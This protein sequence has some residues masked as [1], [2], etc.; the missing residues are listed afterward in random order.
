L[1]SYSTGTLERKE[2]ARRADGRECPRR[3]GSKRRVRAGK[4]CLGHGKE[5]GREGERK[6]GKVQ[7]VPVPVR[8]VGVEGQTPKP[9]Q[10]EPLDNG[11]DGGIGKNVLIQAHLARRRHLRVRPL[12]TG[13]RAGKRAGGRV[14]RREDVS[15]GDKR[16]FLTFV[17]LPYY[18]PSP[19]ID[20]H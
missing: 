8:V 11:L 20:P 19:E 5:G 2:K 7:V 14:G 3:R 4:E 10:L 13:G 15:E 12:R 18:V 6:G 9:N 17:C 16:V 1:R